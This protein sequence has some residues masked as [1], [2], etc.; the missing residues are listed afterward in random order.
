[1]PIIVPPWPWERIHSLKSKPEVTHMHKKYSCILPQNIGTVPTV[2]WVD[3]LE[4]A[5]ITGLSVHTLRAHRHL[6]RGIPYTK[7]GRS[8]RYSV[9]DVE[10]FMKQHRVDP[11]R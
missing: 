7:I 10:S 1:M 5:Q 8:V 2:R 4:T 11:A 6:R 3:E 9:F